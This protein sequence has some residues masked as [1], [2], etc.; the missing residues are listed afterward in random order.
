MFKLMRQKV[1]VPL[2][3]LGPLA[4]AGSLSLLA[5]ANMFCQWLLASSP[6]AL[7][8]Q[9][10]LSQMRD[11]LSDRMERKFRVPLAALQCELCKGFP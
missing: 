1:H 11:E 7:C 8:R 2:F 3:C 4:S 9:G 6:T 5:A 10:I